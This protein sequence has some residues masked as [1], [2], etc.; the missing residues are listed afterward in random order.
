MIQHSRSTLNFKDKSSLLRTFN[1]GIITSGQTNIRFTKKLEK[2]LETGH[3]SLFSSGSSALYHILKGLN[4]KEGDSVLLPDYICDNVLKAVV[5][6]GCRPVLYDNEKTSWNSNFNKISARMNES[7]K[8]I[9]I[10]HA[11]SI[12]FPDLE[13]IKKIN[14]PVIEDC[15]HALTSKINNIKISA[16]SKASFYSF[17][18]T[19]LIAT[20]E[21]GA[22]ATNDSDL[23]K[24]ILKYSV[25]KCLS[26]L[27]SSIGIS[28]LEKLPGFLKRRREIA[29]YY[30]KELAGFANNGIKNS[31]YFRYPLL[32][33][34]PGTFMK[35]R[36]VAFRK[37]VDALLHQKT[38]SEESLFPNVNEVFKR[39][40]SLPI[41]PSLSKKEMSIVIEETKRILD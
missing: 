19:K 18:A 22:V 36:K 39:T 32:V 16:F 41:Y 24:E 7:V 17:N 4:L 15:A 38:G 3:V 34:S 33:D 37:G 23:H 26:D 25:D 9:I 35:N 30:D 6:A 10:N 27:S 20:G 13:Q 11:F 8:A 1:S 14:A 31:V 29:A 12:L 28:Q 40:I 21:G 5:S 2:Y